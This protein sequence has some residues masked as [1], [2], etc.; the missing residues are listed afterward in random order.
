MRGATTSRSVQLFSSRPASPTVNPTRLGAPTTSETS[1]QSRK[2]P[3]RRASH[4]DHVGSDV[5]ELPVEAQDDL[6][7]A[8]RSHESD[9][10]AHPCGEPGSEVDD[11]GAHHRQGKGQDDCIGF[12][13]AAVGADADPSVAPV[14][15]PHR[16][17][18][19]DLGGLERG[20]WVAG[21]TRYPR[22]RRRREPIDPGRTRRGRGRRRRLRTRARSPIQE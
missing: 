8:P 18:G 1:Y 4:P 9:R 3:C 7:H 10:V 2:R 11:A 16:A 6:L 21:R 22:R 13:G 19:A 20:A 15:A 17:A 5:P 12:Q 14:E